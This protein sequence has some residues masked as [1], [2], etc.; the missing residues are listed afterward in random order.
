[1]SVGSRW[2]VAALARTVRDDRERGPASFQELAAKPLCEFRVQ[3]RFCHQRPQQVGQ[4]LLARKPVAGVEKRAEVRRVAAVVRD[5]DVE[6]GLGG[7]GFEQ[8]VCL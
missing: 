2:E 7:A 6:V 5:R 3:L 4:R 8:D 1:V